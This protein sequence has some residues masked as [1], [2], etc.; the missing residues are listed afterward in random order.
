M[1]L[2]KLLIDLEDIEKNSGRLINKKFFNGTNAKSSKYIF[3]RKNVLY[4]K[5]RVYLN[6]VIIA[7]EDGYC[8]SEILP[9]N[10]GENIFNRYAQCV[11]MSPMFVNYATQ[12]SY[13]TKMPRL[14]TT[15]GKLALIPLPPLAEQKRIVAKLNELLPLCD[16][17]SE[18]IN[19]F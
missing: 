6:K 7:E 13:G 2:G 17:L 4:G 1:K 10:F 16:A 18:K 19:H 5:L 12:V 11:L 15:D 8:S 3:R 9:L 14:G